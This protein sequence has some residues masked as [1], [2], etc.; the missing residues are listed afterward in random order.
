[1][2]E[3]KDYDPARR[4]SLDEIAVDYVRLIRKAQPHGPY[5]LCGLCVAG[6]IA[7][8]CAQQLRKAGESVPLLILSDIWA[9]GFLAAFPL[10]RKLIYH[11]NYRLHTLR[12]RIEIVR[13]GKASLTEVLSSFTLA[14]KSRVLDLAAAIGLINGAE[15]SKRVVG[16]DNWLFLLSLE[17]ARNAYKIAP[18]QSDVVIF[19]SDEVVIRF[20]DPNM[21][22]TDL[23][24]G[25]LAIHPIPGWHEEMFQD[26]GARLIASR[27]KPH[28]EAVDAARDLSA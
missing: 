13:T 26:Q 9:P 27:L 3:P 21:G 4:R 5:I 14:R 7:Y 12:H 17:A 28:L 2:L 15:I 8:E 6:A 19:R 23:V 20:A 25:H 16:R 22:W 18:T 1:M 10:I 11:F 24:K